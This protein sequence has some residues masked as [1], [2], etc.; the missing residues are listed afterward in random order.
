MLLLF[1][2]VLHKSNMFNF[3]PKAIVFPQIWNDHFLALYFSLVSFVYVYS[4]SLK[5]K[6]LF[7]IP[8]NFTSR[9]T[10]KAKGTQPPIWS[11]A[12][13]PKTVRKKFKLPK[14]KWMV[15]QLPFWMAFLLV[16]QEISFKIQSMF[17]QLSPETLSRKT[18]SNEVIE[19]NPS[20]NNGLN[21]TIKKIM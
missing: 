1:Y 17:Q 15:V 9:V 7:G 21:R 6:Q 12:N 19:I 20:K 3:P 10:P 16:V 14:G 8:S 4:C 11:D 2:D 5:K 13:T 18:I